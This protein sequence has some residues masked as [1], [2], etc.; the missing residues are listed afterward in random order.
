MQRPMSMNG[1]SWVEGNTPNMV[2]PS[3]KQTERDCSE[4]ALSNCNLEG[5][6]CEVICLYADR[7]METARRFND[8]AITNMSDEAFA[9]MIAAKFIFEDATQ[10]NS[11]EGL[12]NQLLSG[13]GIDPLFRVVW[14]TIGITG[15]IS[16][17][18]G[19][20]PLSQARNAA[21]WWRENAACLGFDVSIFD[22]GIYDDEI[23][24]Q[25]IPNLSG[26]GMTCTI[27]STPEN[28]ASIELNSFDGQTSWDEWLAVTMLQTA[29]RAQDYRNN[30]DISN[31]GNPRLVDD[32]D[33]Q[34]SAYI[35]ALGCQSPPWNVPPIN[36][37]SVPP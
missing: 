29:Q 1:Y 26:F 27:I 17:G 3:G 6:E 4:E 2:D 37:Q 30:S 7:W 25:C 21:E 9:A 20:I 23:V 14:E 33:N 11:Q 13:A 18:P 36:G 15:E 34:V 10:F 32:M 24:Q 19:N 22:S 31:W 12:L 8:P 16:Y 28:R 35:I 5:S